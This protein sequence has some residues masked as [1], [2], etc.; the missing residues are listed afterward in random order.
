MT[1]LSNTSAL[2]S[3]SRPRQYEIAQYWDLPN[4]HPAPHLPNQASRLT[5]LNDEIFP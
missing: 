2:A 4:I 1:K 3:R 5:V